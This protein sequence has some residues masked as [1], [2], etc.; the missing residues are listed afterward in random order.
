MARLTRMETYDPHSGDLNVIIETPKGSR[1]KLRYDEKER[2]FT[3]C[4]VLPAGSVFPFDFGFVPSTRGEDGDPVDVLLLL[5]DPV[6][7]GC[8]VPC[9]L[10]GVIEAE[11]TQKEE[12]VRNDRLIAVASQSHIHRNVRSLEDLPAELLNEIEH[13]FT[14]YHEMS[15]SQFKPIARRGAD[16]AE[17]LVKQGERREKKEARAERREGKKAKK[18]RARVN[19]G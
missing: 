1:N 11:Q 2:L 12:T 8:L 17:A 9:R 19:K 15:G 14:S 6:P 3:L 16:Q 5:E 4:K 7:A 13:F 18:K 10:V